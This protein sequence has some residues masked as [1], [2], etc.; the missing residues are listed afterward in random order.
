MRGEVIIRIRSRVGVR[1]SQVA[2]NM[3]GRSNSRALVPEKACR[4]RR[5]R[6]GRWERLTDQGLG[7]LGPLFLRP[8]RRGVEHQQ[9][10][11]LSGPR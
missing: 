5:T 2:A 9:A 4:Q 11:L 10:G 3:D 8:S 6:E 1:F 7:Q